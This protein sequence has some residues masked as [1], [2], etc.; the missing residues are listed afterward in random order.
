MKGLELIWQH[1]L[2]AMLDSWDVAAHPL[3]ETVALP[4]AHEARLEPATPPFPCNTRSSHAAKQRKSI[5]T[6]SRASASI[7]AC[8]ARSILQGYQ[9]LLPLPLRQLSANVGAHA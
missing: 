4:P 3:A 8:Y 1:I 9:S 7:E 6:A 2:C 5:T